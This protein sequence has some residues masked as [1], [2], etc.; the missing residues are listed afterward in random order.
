[1]L[2]TDNKCEETQSPEDSV[3][4]RLGC[5]LVGH[6]EIFTAQTVVS[7]YNKAGRILQ[8]DGGSKFDKRPFK[9]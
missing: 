6:L 9:T 2:T 8:Q 1:M 7:A 4:L 5:L 3:M